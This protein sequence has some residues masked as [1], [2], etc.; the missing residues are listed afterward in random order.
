MTAPDAPDP[1]PTG[2]EPGASSNPRGEGPVGLGDRVGGGHTTSPDTNQGKTEPM[3]PT[4]AHGDLTSG[5]PGAGPGG[6]MTVA[7]NDPQGVNPTGLPP[8]EPI[9][10]ALGPTSAA[11]DAAGDDQGGSLPGSEAAT[12]GTSETSGRVS[13]VH[14]PPL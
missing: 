7:G 3:P 4:V 11:P 5:A 10:Q 6:G 8:R 2:D 13:G 1:L 14:T 9:E 12:D